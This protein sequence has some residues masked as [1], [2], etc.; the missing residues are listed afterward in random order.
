MNSIL[1]NILFLML[2]IVVACSPIEEVKVESTQLM[3]RFNQA[4]IDDGS[5]PNDTR[6]VSLLW[7]QYDDNEKL[8]AKDSILVENSSALPWIA[9]EGVHCNLSSSLYFLVNTPGISKHLPLGSMLQQLRLLSLNYSDVQYIP[10]LGSLKGTFTKDDPTYC[11]TLERMMCKVEFM[12]THTLASPA[13]LTF[14]KI[15]VKR[16]TNK[17]SLLPSNELLFPEPLNVHYMDLEF[18]NV[19]NGGWSGYLPENRRGIGTGTTSQSKNKHNA[20]QGQADYCTHLVVSG[21]YQATPSDPVHPLSFVFYL[22][23]D[24]IRDYNLIRNGCYTINVVIANL[25]TW[26]TR[27]I[28]ENGLTIEQLPDKEL[29]NDIEF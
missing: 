18:I 20:P 24:A 2:W 12:I 9:V 14:N 4:A 13:L 15:T 8:I 7:L 29:T 28:Y 25:N 26:D 17:I 22:G 6:I 11:I 5:L 19:E 3:F 10:M 21:T 1:Q 23:R 16:V 27:I